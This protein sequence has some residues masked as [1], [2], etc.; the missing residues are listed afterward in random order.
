MCGHDPSPQ[1]DRGALGRH[2]PVQRYGILTRGGRH[3]SKQ[4]A[5]EPARE[6]ANQRARALEAQ[7]ATL[8]LPEAKVAAPPRG[9]GREWARETERLRK[10]WIMI[11]QRRLGPAEQK[12][13]GAMARW[14]QP[15]Y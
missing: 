3:V 7:S 9:K 13:A 8:R 15:N 5:V 12:I 1:V 6:G 10:A 4:I 11:A 2:G 14:V